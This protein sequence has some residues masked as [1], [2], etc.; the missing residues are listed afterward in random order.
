MMIFAICS[1][2]G[3]NGEPVVSYIPSAM[4]DIIPLMC[5]RRLMEQGLDPGKNARRPASGRRL[6]SFALYLGASGRHPVGQLRCAR[7]RA[8]SVRLQ[9]P[10][11]S[12]LKQH[13]N[14]RVRSAEGEPY[15]GDA[16]TATAQRACSPAPSSTAAPVA[17]QFDAIASSIAEDLGGEDQLSTVQKHLIE[18]FAGCA[19]VLSD[20]NTRAMTG[21]EAIDLL[22]YSTAVSTLVRVANKIGLRRIPKDVTPSLADLLREEPREA[23]DD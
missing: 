12:R 2:L 1:S 6:R 22:A 13:G 14:R 20:I 4:S 17:K 11:L 23:A 3:A 21:A 18:A 16:A 19:V 5:A 15:A 7:A 8:A 10:A 9:A